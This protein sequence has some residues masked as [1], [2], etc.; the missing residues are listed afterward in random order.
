VAAAAAP[1]G[2]EWFD[3]ARF[4]FTR[5]DVDAALRLGPH[6]HNGWYLQQL[7]KLY[8]PFVVPG[9]SR[10]VLVVD[11]DAQFLQPV[12][13]VAAGRALYHPATEAHQPYFDHMARLDPLLRRAAPISGVAHHA[14]FE[15]DVLGAL[16][17]RVESST[18]F[19]QPAWRALLDAVHPGFRHWSGMSEYEMYVHFAIANFPERVALRQ[20]AARLHVPRLAGPPDTAGMDLVVSHLGEDADRQQG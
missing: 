8:A 17:A 20:L 19:T 7:L 12:A 13:F 14:L 18:G 11:A 16:L 5:A 6:P 10:A 3:E 2:V 1:L 15:R 9:L 4:P